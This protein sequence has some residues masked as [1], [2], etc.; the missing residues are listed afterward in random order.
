MERRG[1]RGREREELRESHLIGEGAC[2]GAVRRRVV[3]LTH[4]NVFEEEI[5]PPEG[6]F[7]NLP[8]SLSPPSPTPTPLTTPHARRLAGSPTLPDADQF[9]FVGPSAHAPAPATSPA[10]ALPGYPGEGV[11]S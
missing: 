3:K 7:V 11:A 4:E 8:G 2:C 6:I 1:E 9:P 5:F 10:P